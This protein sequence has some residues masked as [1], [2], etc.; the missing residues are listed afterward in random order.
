[1]R[2]LIPFLSVIYLAISPFVIDFLLSVHLII[3]SRYPVSF[4]YYL[5]YQSLLSVLLTL[6]FSERSDHVLAIQFLIVLTHED[7]PTNFS[8]RKRRQSPQLER[9]R[10]QKRRRSRIAIFLITGRN[11]VQR[12]RTRG[13]QRSTDLFEN[14][15][16]V[17]VSDE[18]KR[19]IVTVQR[20]V[21]FEHFDRKHKRSWTWKW[22]RSWAEG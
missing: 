11:V 13:G 18:R 20:I 9:R 14:S 8:P 6:I 21:R 22:N 3:S 1:M 5:R 10:S 17:Q 19:I 2:L 16:S 7:D 15:T 4:S 12:T